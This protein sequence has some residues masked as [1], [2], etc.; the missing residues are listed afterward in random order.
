MLWDLLFIVSI[1]KSFCLSH[2]KIHIHIYFKYI[3]HMYIPLLKYQIL[4]IHFN[5]SEHWDCLWFGLIQIVQLWSFL[6]MSYKEHIHSFLLLTNLLVNLF[7]CTI[8]PSALVDTGKKYY[9]ISVLKFH[10]HHQY[11][12]IA[13]IPYYSYYLIFSTFFSLYSSL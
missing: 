4:R 1:I 2:C 11:M 5:V 9:I 8:L 12:R 13:S 3:L 6:Y 10:T 7:P